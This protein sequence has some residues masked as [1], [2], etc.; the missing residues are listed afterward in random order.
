MCEPILVNDWPVSYHADGPDK[1]SSDVGGVDQYWG[2]SL[3][4]SLPMMLPFNLQAVYPLFLLYSTLCHHFGM[5][6]NSAAL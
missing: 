1:S 5:F 2:G 3:N 6:S 4:L